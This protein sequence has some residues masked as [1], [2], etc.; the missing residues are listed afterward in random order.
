[1]RRCNFRALRRDADVVVYHAT[2]ANQAALAGKQRQARYHV[3]IAS[4]CAEMAM[5]SAR[6]Q[7]GLPWRHL[8]GTMEIDR[9]ETH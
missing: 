3:R 6:C 5:L 8:I 4:R 7:Y 9:D 2:Q 1:M